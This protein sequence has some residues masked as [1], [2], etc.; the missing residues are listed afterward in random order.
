MSAVGRLNVSGLNIYTGATTVDAGTLLIP[1][2]GSITSTSQVLVGNAAGSNA[3]LQISGGAVSSSNNNPSVGIGTAANTV[4]ALNMSSGTINSGNE[5]WIGYVSD[6]TAYGAF[7]MS[8]GLVNCG[9]WFTVGRGANGIF[10]MSGGTLA[11]T[12]A[13]ILPR[14]RSAPIPIMRQ[15]S[16]EAARL[17]LRMPSSCPSSKTT[18][19][20]S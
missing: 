14:E 1:V 12:G 7:T 8:G 10:N 11:V 3:L 6:N 13:D 4:G 2:G 18:I 19:S 9:N 17:T 5:F 15:I 16:P 20:R